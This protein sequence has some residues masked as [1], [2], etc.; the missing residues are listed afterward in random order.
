MSEPIWCNVTVHVPATWCLDDTT[1][2]IIDWLERALI[3]GDTSDDPVEG[4]DNRV[5]FRVNG[6]GNYGLF[7][8]ELEEA[9]DWCHEHH[10]PY[11]AHDESKYDMQGEIRWY[12]GGNEVISGRFDSEVVLT[13][14]QWRS[15]QEGKFNF[16]TPNEYFERLSR[17][18]S[19]VT[20]DHLPEQEPTSDSYE[21][22]VVL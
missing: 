3:N 15:M 16:A 21:S 17:T 12:D 18:L 1:P 8:D 9:F 22:R 19:D 6:E 11:I 20:I 5:E 14:Q 7:D 10:V 4:H 2:T 13:E